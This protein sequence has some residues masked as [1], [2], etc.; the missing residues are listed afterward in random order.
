MKPRRLSMFD[1][2]LE[3]DAGMD[4]AA[5]SVSAVHSIISSNDHENMNLQTH[6]CLQDNEAIIFVCH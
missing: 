4:D 1:G 3:V 5:V 6:E 2:D